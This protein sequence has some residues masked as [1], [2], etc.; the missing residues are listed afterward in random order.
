MG[1]YSANSKQESWSGQI[2]YLQ[3]AVKVFTKRDYLPIYPEIYLFYRYFD[4]ASNSL[5]IFVAII[6]VGTY[7]LF[8]HAIAHLDY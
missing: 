3:H 6:F 5:A 4:V 7:S 1:E 2:T 8:D